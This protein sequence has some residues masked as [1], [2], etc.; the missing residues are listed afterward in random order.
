[1]KLRCRH[2]LSFPFFILG[3]FAR[4]RL[5]ICRLTA[6]HFFWRCDDRCR[7]GLPILCDRCGTY[8]LRYTFGC[9]KL[10]GQVSRKSALLDEEAYLWQIHVVLPLTLRQTLPAHCTDQRSNQLE[11]RRSSGATSGP[12]V[13]RAA[14]AVTVSSN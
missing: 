7:C 3:I 9:R 10:V 6:A 4:I 5:T 8:T 11:F 12:P 14:I 1:M 13:C 2:L